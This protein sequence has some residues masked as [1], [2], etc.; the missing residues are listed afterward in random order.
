MGNDLGHGVTIGL[1]ILG[2]E[3]ASREP[4]GGRGSGIVNKAY[5]SSLLPQL[6]H[7]FL[8]LSLGLWRSK[9]FVHVTLSIASNNV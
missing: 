8:V 9:P 1:R 3:K 2:Y 4:L 5:R 6:F 7:V